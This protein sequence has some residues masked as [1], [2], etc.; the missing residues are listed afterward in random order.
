VV[1]ARG[2][3]VRDVTSQ[4]RPERCWRSEQHTLLIQDD[5]CS[6]K[7]SKRTMASVKRILLDAGLGWI[8]CYSDVKYHSIHAGSKTTRTSCFLY[9]KGSALCSR[10]TTVLLVCPSARFIGLNPS[11]THLEPIDIVRLMRQLAGL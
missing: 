9:K 6:C 1:K 8:D 11:T 5:V 4:S 7:D 10:W 2:E 3:M